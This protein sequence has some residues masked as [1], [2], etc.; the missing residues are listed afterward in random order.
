MLTRKW[1]NLTMVF[2]EYTYQCVATII[3]IKLTVDSGLLKTII[4][5]PF[6]QW[7]PKLST[8]FHLVPQG[9]DLLCGL[10]EEIKHMLMSK[11]VAL[12][13]RS[14]ASEIIYDDECISCVIVCGPAVKSLRRGKRIVG[15]MPGYYGKWPWMTSLIFNN[16]H[17]C[18]GSIL[19]R[20]WIVTTSHCFHG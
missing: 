12:C 5:Y 20:K 10:I 9:R 17:Y 18:A 15:G 3:T 8:V 11:Y 7:V 14:S 2:L 16:S 4:F 19:G 6:Q 13:D 1:L